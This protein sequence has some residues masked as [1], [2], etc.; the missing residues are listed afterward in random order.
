[1]VVGDVEKLTPLGEYS[2]ETNEERLAAKKEEL[3][4]SRGKANGNNPAILKNI[5]KKAKSN[6][7]TRTTPNGFV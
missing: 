4:R 1:V 7:A 3:K 5:S 6:Y 2:M